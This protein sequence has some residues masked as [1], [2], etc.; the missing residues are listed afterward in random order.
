M[1]IHLLHYAHGNEHMG[2]HDV[3]RDTWVKTCN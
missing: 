3:I 2:T 1:V